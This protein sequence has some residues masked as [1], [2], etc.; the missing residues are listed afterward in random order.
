[1]ESCPLPN[2][3]IED[4]AAKCVWRSKVDNLTKFNWEKRAN[5]Y[6]GRRETGEGEAESSLLPFNF[7]VNHKENRNSIPSFLL[8]EVEVPKKITRSCKMLLI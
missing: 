8:C 7:T 3:I 1:M 5:Y 2:L 4:T 6:E